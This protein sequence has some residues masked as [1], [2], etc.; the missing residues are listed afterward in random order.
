MSSRGRILLLPVLTLFTAMIASQPAF[1]TN[2]YTSYLGTNY[3]FTGIQETS[4]Y[5]DAELPPAG[6]GT[7]CFDDPT[8]VGNSLYFSPPSFA[9]SAAGTDVYDDPIGAQLQLTITA[10]AGSKI[11][12]LNISDLGTLALSGPD[13]LGYTSVFATMVGFVTVEEVNYVGVTPYV[14]NFNANGV[15]RSWRHDGLHAR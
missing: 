9:A 14:I 7:C 8:G 10:H 11:D 13:G 4:T 2:T 5:G 1:A 12:I 6:A 15:E 3:D